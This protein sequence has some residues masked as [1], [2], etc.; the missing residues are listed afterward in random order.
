MAKSTAYSM[1]AVSVTVDGRAVVGFWD[2]DDAVE[3]A[4][5]ADV[6][7]GVIGADGSGIF[8]QM[9]DKSATITLRLMHTSATHRQLTQRLAAQRAGILKGFPVSVVDRNSNEGGSTDQAFVQQAPSDVKGKNAGVR[10]WVLW[11]SDWERNIP[12]P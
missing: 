7:T 11:S 10:E 4:E 5:G 8:S 1:L 6:G 3:I 9:A 12:N 2:G